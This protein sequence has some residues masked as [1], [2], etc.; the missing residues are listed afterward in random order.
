MAL[1]LGRTRNDIAGSQD[2]LLNSIKLEKT[3]LPKF[4]G[5]N[6]AELNSLAQFIEEK[7]TKSSNYSKD[8]TSANADATLEHMHDALLKLKEASDTDDTAQYG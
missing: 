2:S 1:N 5:K 4:T 8:L 3:A 7:L 6:A